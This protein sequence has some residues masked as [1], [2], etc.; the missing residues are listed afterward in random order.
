MN[1]TEYRLQYQQKA[2]NRYTPI[3]SKGKLHK[4]EVNYKFT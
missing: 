3:P 4:K 1:R 2:F